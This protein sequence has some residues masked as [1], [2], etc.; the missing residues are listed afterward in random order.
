MWQ[1]QQGKFLHM[2]ICVYHIKVWPQVI[3]KSFVNENNITSVNIFTA[4]LDENLI[5]F[6]FFQEHRFQ[7]SMYTKRV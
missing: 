3:T 2:T 7:H 5:I 4:D 6:A 1:P